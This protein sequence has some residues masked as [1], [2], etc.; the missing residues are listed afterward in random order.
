MSDSNGQSTTL[1]SPKCNYAAFVC[2]GCDV[3]L[4][5]TVAEAFLLADGQYVNCQHC[6]VSLQAS[7]S[8]QCALVKVHENK[9][10]AGKLILPFALVWFSVSLLVAIFV[11]TK[12][13]LIMTPIGVL[14]IYAINSVLSDLS[15]AIFLEPLSE[16]DS[17][18]AVEKFDKTEE[19]DLHSV[20]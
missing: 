2:N 16:G 20:S 1:E 9:A 3:E 11:D 8:D 12:I 17:G 15:E 13:S 6:K 7:A 14:I 19:E 10:K 18:L 5:I 4:E